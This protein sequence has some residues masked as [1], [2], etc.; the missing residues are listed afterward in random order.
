MPFAYGRRYGFAAIVA[1]A[2]AR[3]SLYTLS[4]C[5]TPPLSLLIT[6]C[7]AGAAAMPVVAPYAITI[8][9]AEAFRYYGLPLLQARYYAP[10]L[11]ACLQHELLP[12]FCRPAILPPFSAQVHTTLRLSSFAAGLPPVAMMSMLSRYNMAI[13][14]DTNV[15]MALPALSLPLFTCHILITSSRRAIRLPP[16]LPLLFHVARR[17][18]TPRLTPLCS[19]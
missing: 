13:I 4:A 2:R 10:S 8:A 5:A 9:V 3:S 18:P 7:A 11:R 12:A 14:S 6:P 19:L 1:A 17:L 16:V 15:N